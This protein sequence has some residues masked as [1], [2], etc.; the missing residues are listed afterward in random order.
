[1]EVRRDCWGVMAVVVRHRWI[2]RLKQPAEE[3]QETIETESARHVV[4]QDLPLVRQAFFE[5]VWETRNSEP[6]PQLS[7]WMA[8]ITTIWIVPSNRAICGPDRNAPPTKWTEPGEVQKC[9]YGTCW[10]DLTGLLH[11]R[12]VVSC[13][14]RG[15]R[16]LA[17]QMAFLA[18]PEGCL[19]RQPL[20]L[21]S[22]AVFMMPAAQRLRP[23][24]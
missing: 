12:R 18:L 6:K 4:V 20:P 16:P 8:V 15:L 13:G 24:I 3:G 10:L 23:V 17:Y 5:T 14:F 1:M 11:P 19:H 2:S 22:Y 21:S 7:G 9:R